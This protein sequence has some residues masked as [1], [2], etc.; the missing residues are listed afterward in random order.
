MDSEPFVRRCSVENMNRHLLNSHRLVI[1]WSVDNWHN[2][3][4]RLVDDKPPLV[5][6][7]TMTRPLSSYVNL[8]TLVAHWQILTMDAMCMGLIVDV[9]CM[10]WFVMHIVAIVYDNWYM[11]MMIDRG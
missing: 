3:M 9:H 1:E 5:L 4:V 2:S 7:H 8:V 10:V 6:I 11:V